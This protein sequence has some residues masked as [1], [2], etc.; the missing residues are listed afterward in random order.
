MAP[1]IYPDVN[2]FVGFQHFAGTRPSAFTLSL[3]YGYTASQPA[4]GTGS[5]IDLQV[6]FYTY[7][8]FNGGTTNCGFLSSLAAPTS[9]VAGPFTVST[10]SSSGT[11][12]TVDTTVA[13]LLTN[14]QIVTVTATANATSLTSGAICTI[15]TAGTTDFTLIGAVD[16]NVGTQF[17]ATGPGSGTGTVTLNCQNSARTVAGSSGTSFT[18]TSAVS[19]TFAAITVL[20]GTVTVSKSWNFYAGGSAD[21]SFVGDTSFGH[22]NPAQ[23]VDVIG[24]GWFRN[25]SNQDGVL[26]SGRA[27][28]VNGRNVTLTP[29]TLS[30]S[31]TLTLP[32]ATGTIALVGGSSTGIL[33]PPA[34]VA[35]ANGAPL[36]FAAGTNLTTPEAGAIEYDGTYFY[37]TP[38]TTSG[39]GH[40]GVFQTFRLTSNGSA[41]GPG[42]ADFF[43]TTSA[44]NLAATSVYEI[45]F[46]AY[47]QKIT[48][49]ALT[50]TLTAS[51]APTLITGLL[52]A[53][54]L[55]G[56]A[57]GAPTTL[58]TGSRAA[59]TAAFGTTGSITASAF[60]AYEFH[61]RVITNAA[62]SFKLQVTSGVG[63][64]TPQAGSFYTVR[65]VSGTTGAFV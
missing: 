48:A 9:G 50:W 58:Y 15:L 24:S 41:I 44:I 25:A 45:E 16:N 21:N 51:S 29:A 63:T 65:Q 14:G 27:G 37:A 60:M 36:D 23:K 61:V 56:I 10:I 7:A 32:D 19:S 38:T 11:T 46:F 18:Y 39:R 42:I 53:G 43:G 35:S 30:A 64:V 54:P 12:V 3:N 2:S 47:L 57:A 40:S 20:A 17:T 49:G 8:S 34:G 1:S 6:G 26:I 4:L 28:G 33:R 59:A 5:V 13:H 31:Q 55:T 62:T 52:R 22:S